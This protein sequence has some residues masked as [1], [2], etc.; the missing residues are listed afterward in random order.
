[1]AVRVLSSEGKPSGTLDSDHD[2]YVEFD[3]FA[4]EVHG[5]LCVGFD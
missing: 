5:N 3:F 1:M 2:V 4:S